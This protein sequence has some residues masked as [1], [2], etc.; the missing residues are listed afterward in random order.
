[1]SVTRLGTVT[2]SGQVSVTRSELGQGS[3]TRSGTESGEGSG[4][5]KGRGV[6]L[7]GGVG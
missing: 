4:I 3:V 6:V 5:K 2:R 7:G 1:M